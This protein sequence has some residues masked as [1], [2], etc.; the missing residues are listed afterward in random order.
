MI[1]LIA[2]ALF[3]LLFLIC[4]IPIWGVEWLI[5]KKHPYAADISQLRMV[6]WAFKV[7]LFLSG[8]RI[9]VEGEE[10]V[11]KEEAV[12]YIGNHRGFFDTVVTYQR[13]PGLTGYVAK[14]SIEHVPLLS[15]W[16]K[17]LH[18]Q[19]LNR[20]DKKA[21]LKT[22]LSCIEQIKNGVSICIFPEGTRNPHPEDGWNQ[23]RKRRRHGNA[24]L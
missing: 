21:G 13:C 6:Q 12:L 2:V 9:T 24:T 22:I 20:D 17:R 4:S 5:A 3:V 8:T 19:F 1:R 14:D 11:P 16:M 15:M 18:C 23:V 7:V 10:N